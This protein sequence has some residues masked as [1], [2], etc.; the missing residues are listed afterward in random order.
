MSRNYVSLSIIIPAYNEENHIKTCLD[1]IA[2]QTIRPHE[3]IVV[4]NGSSDNTAKIARSYDFVRVVTEQ[5]RGIAYARDAGF[6]A[7]VSSFLGRIDADTM[8][9]PDWVERVQTFYMHKSH[10]TFALTGGAT[11]RNIPFPRLSGQMQKYLAFR[12]SWLALS[13]HILWG[14]NMVVPRKA[15][16]EVKA[17]VCHAPVIHEDIDL[18]I[19]LHR[20]KVRIIYQPSL[21]V[22]A[23]LKRIYSDQDKLWFNLKWWPRTLKR[24]GKKRWPIT[25]VAAFMVYACASLTRLFSAERTHR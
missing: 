15:W 4:D 5:R 23:V 22:S 18:A 14:S 12:L 1:S 3:V 25:L 24:H 11:F 19:H 7:A 6:N 8:L 17:Y 21:S 20:Q 13:H 9:P 2:A 10:Q 16:D